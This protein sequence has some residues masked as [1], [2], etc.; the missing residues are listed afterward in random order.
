MVR[1]CD[2]TEFVHFQRGKT[3]QQRHGSFSHCP[4]ETHLHRLLMCTTDS[5]GTTHMYKPQQDQGLPVSDS[6][7]TGSFRFSVIKK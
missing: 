4:A 3:L 1:D 6:S 2:H 7:V 5:S